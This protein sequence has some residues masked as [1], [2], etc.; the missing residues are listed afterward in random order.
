MGFNIIPSQA[1]KDEQGNLLDDPFDPRSYEWLV[2]YPVEVSWANISGVDK[3][4]ISKFSATAQFDFFSNVQAS[5]TTHCT[6]ATIEL[7]EE[8]IEPIAKAIFE[9]IRDNRGYVG[10]AL[11]A[12]FDSLETFPRLPFE[13]IDKQTYDRLVAEVQA[14]AIETDFA[15]A[16]A[17]YDLKEFSTG[18][19]AAPCD[20]DKCLLPSAK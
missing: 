18:T 12:R 7:R 15:T 6:S 10:A 14:R 13:P 1:C 8:E 17:K 3:I 19:G 16:L 20:S 2:E 9:N 11:L 5:W 4:D